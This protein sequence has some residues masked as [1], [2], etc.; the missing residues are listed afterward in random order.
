MDPSAGHLRTRDWR[1]GSC[2]RRARACVGAWL[3]P[4]LARLTATSVAGLLLYASF[5]PRNWWWAAFVAFALLAWVLTHPATTPC[6]GLGYGFLFGLA[7]YVPLLPWISLLVG[8][9]PWVALATMS[10]L[11]PG[12][13]R[14]VRRGGAAG[15]RLADLVRRACGRPRSG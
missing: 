11:F 6:G 8:D 15:A 5:P 9:V 14:P 13:V 12:A 2:G 7:F 1:G 4:R 3:V 10:A